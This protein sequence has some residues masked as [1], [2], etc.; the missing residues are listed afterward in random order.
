MLNMKW[1]QSMFITDTAVGIELL[2]HCGPSPANP[3]PTYPPVV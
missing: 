2:I 3:C 1:K